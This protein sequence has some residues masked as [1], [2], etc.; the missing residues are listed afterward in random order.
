MHR[1]ILI[2]VSPYPPLEKHDLFCFINFPISPPPSTLEN[3]TVSILSPPAATI[4]ISAPVRLL[5]QMRGLSRI[6]RPWMN[7]I[8]RLQGFEKLGQAKLYCD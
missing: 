6:K 2:L 5:T 4:E 7:V 3:G 1:F 8:L